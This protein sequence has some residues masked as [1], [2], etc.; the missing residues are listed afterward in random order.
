MSG[1]N[2][3]LKDVVNYLIRDRKNYKKLTNK[4]KEYNFFIINRLMSKKYPLISNKLNI[5]SIDK[6]LG[7]DMWFFHIGQEIKKG[8]I[9][10]SFF[11]W[12]WSKS[13]I[14]TSRENKLNIKDNNYLL[15]RI[16]LSQ[17]DLNFLLKFY[18]DDVI[19]EMKYLKKLDKQY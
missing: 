13:I 18:P 14:S 1:I 17:D 10:Y 19:E 12:F 3:N 15:K 7:L 9:D 4:E 5:K 11:K 16:N 6:S 2:S 8:N